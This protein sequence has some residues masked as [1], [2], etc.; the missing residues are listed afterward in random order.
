M[1]RFL[2]L[3]AT[4][5]ALAGCASQ[6]QQVDHLLSASPSGPRSHQIAHVP[7]IL[8]S[9]GLCGPAALSMVMGTYERNISVDE[10]AKQVYTPGMK[11]TFQSDMISASR[12]NGMLAIPIEGF[13]ALLAEIAADHPVIV[14]ENLLLSWLPQWHYAV[15]FGFDLDRET[16][17][18]HSGPEKSKIWD[19]RKL[20]RSW[21]LADYWGLVVLP[22]NLL[23]ASADE[24]SHAKA[25]A[26]LEQAGHRTEALVAY[27]TMLSKWPQ[28]LT[29]LIGLSG[30]AF[31]D[32]K[33]KKAVALL[34]IATVHHPTYASAW[35]NRALAES[36]AKMT[37]SARSSARRALD[38]VS[39]ELR[40]QYERSLAEIAK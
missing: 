9:S 35:H 26:G 32:G 1:R 27:K 13:S 34:T 23:S 15:V 37:T 38:L 21:K 3:C 2:L 33:F 39:A 14:F 12:R 16:I 7:F 11:G 4:L 36:A 40:P 17:Q 24:F 5:V 18:L 28:S 29:A 31:E 30:Q 20:E 25:A 19:I 22:P 10:I 8:Q 6:T